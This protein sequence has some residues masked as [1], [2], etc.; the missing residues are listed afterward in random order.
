MIKLNF[1]SWDNFRH[2]KGESFVEGKE[3]SSI[4]S[5]RGKK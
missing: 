4:S 2:F 3:K 1:S 5:S